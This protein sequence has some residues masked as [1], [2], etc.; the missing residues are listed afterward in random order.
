MSSV[1]GKSTLLLFKQEEYNV[2]HHVLKKAPWAYNLSR[3]VAS[4]RG[5]VIEVQAR[6]TDYKGRSKSER[7]GGF[8]SPP[9]LKRGDQERTE[10]LWEVQ[11]SW[12]ERNR[13]SSRPRAAPFLTRS[14]GSCSPP[15]SVSQKHSSSHTQQPEERSLSDAVTSN[16]DITIIQHILVSPGE[17]ERKYHSLRL[18]NQLTCEPYACSHRI[19]SAHTGLHTGL[20]TPGTDADTSSLGKSVKRERNVPIGETLTVNNR[21]THIDGALKHR[22]CVRS[23]PDRKTPE[24]CTSSV[25]PLGHG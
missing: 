5:S 17:A 3:H 10:S 7:P 8:A 12:T 20:Q 25:K 15:K 21:Q 14:H 11:H 1:L 9:D 6:Q 23:S 4:A 13:S 19:A 2:R 24:T 18:P 16:T 22:L